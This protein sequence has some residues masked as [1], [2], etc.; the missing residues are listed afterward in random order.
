MFDDLPSGLA[1]LHAIVMVWIDDHPTQCKV[2]GILGV[3][4]TMLHQD[5]MLDPTIRVWWNTMT[6]ENIGNIHLPCNV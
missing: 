2:G 1:T 5:I 3:D 6:I 4:A